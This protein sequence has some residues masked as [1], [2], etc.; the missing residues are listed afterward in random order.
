[1]QCDEEEKNRNYN[2]GYVV[3]KKSPKFYAIVIPPEKG[4]MSIPSL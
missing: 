4:P 3:E 2:T 1:M